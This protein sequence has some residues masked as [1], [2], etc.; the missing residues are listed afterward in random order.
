[1]DKATEVMLS[2]NTYSYYI[3]SMTAQITSKGQVTIPV[4]IRR[5]LNLRPGDALQF[6]EDAPF[7]KAVKA[8]DMARMKS[9]VGC[10]RERSSVYGSR[11]WLDETR[12]T[13]DL[14]PDP[15]AHRG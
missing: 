11:T 13:V 7:V 10:C 14:P 5:R 6:D 15:H 8:Y 1:M 3:S 4:S 12:G 2:G 9:A